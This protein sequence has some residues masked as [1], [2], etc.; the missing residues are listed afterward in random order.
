IYDV[1]LALS[2]W[3]FLDEVAPELQARRRAAFSSVAHDYVAQRRL[4]DAIPEEILRL[5][6]EEARTRRGEIAA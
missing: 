3:G 4:V 5:N 2:L 6:P 1:Q